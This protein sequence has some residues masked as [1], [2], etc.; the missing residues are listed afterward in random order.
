[1]LPYKLKNMTLFNEG[2]DYF[3]DCPELTV[4]KVSHQM[5]EHRAAGMI[6]PVMIDQGLEAL[7]LEWKLSGYRE[8]VVAQMGALEHDAVL[9]RALGA[10]QSD[11]TGTVQ[12]VALTMRGRHQMIDPGNWKPGEAGEISVTTPLSYYREEVDGRELL[13]IDMQRGI[14][15]VDGIDRYADIRAAL[16]R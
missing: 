12:Q 7:Q 8:Q 13:E 3:G 2:D 4:P 11:E 9:L 14:Y 16:E 15:R 5:E 10:F 6:G 1:M